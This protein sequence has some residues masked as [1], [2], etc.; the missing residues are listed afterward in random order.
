MASQARH[1]GR[2]RRDG[3]GADA[4]P[5]AQT[6][7]GHVWL[8]QPYM[9][10]ANGIFAKTP[11]GF[12]LVPAV[13]DTD[14]SRAKSTLEVSKRAPRKAA[15]ALGEAREVRAGP[16]P[17]ICLA[18]VANPKNGIAAKRAHALTRSP[19][20]RTTCTPCRRRCRTAWARRSTPAS[21]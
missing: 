3:P 16:W 21:T 18:V 17:L 12:R 7:R 4:Q 11:L 6:P 2:L 9:D 8:A 10:G 13:P 19:P 14:I 20:R 1:L 15:P 5:R